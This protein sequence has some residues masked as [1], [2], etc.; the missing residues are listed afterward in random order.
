MARLTHQ[1]SKALTIASKM[2]DPLQAAIKVTHFYD[3]MKENEVEAF[4]V[5]GLCKMI[6]DVCAMLAAGTFN[7]NEVIDNGKRYAD[8]LAHQPAGA[9]WKNLIHYGQIIQ[10]GRFQRFDYGKATNLKKYGSEQPPEY[11]LSKIKVKTALFT[12]D[13]DI[14]AD[15]EDV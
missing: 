8:K 4:L 12:G 13:V 6:G 7:W 15:P 11:D 14:L 3:I 2:L 1:K 10:S 9:G 5:S